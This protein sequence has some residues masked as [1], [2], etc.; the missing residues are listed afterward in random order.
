[1]SE[2]IAV[3]AITISILINSSDMEY[4]TRSKLGT[5]RLGDVFQVEICE[6]SARDTS[7]PDLG[8][9]YISNGHLIDECQI[10]VG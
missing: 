9:L 6:C 10:P 5:K 3:P 7:R 8:F 2:A 4:S 1:L